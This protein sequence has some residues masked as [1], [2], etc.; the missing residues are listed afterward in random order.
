MNQI[1]LVNS[2]SKKEYKIEPSDRDENTIKQYLYIRYYKADNTDDI[3]RYHP[4]NIKLN[5]VRHNQ[6]TFY[7]IYDLL[8]TIYSD[9]LFVFEDQLHTS[10][11]IQNIYDTHM[12]NL[13]TY[14]QFIFL[15]IYITN[16]LTF[17]KQP[18]NI[19]QVI[20]K[21]TEYQDALA[22]KFMLSGKVKKNTIQK[23]LAY[24]REDDQYRY[25]ILTTTLNVVFDSSDM[26]LVRLVKFF[27]VSKYIPFI[28][29]IHNDKPYL[30][31]Y[32]HYDKETISKWIMKKGDIKKLKG[33][34]FK[35]MFDDLILT[36]ILVNTNDV[37]YKLSLMVSW[38]SSKYVSY[39][40][41]ENN[42][43]AM[44]NGVMNT[45]NHNNNLF[46]YTN[47]SSFINNT[48]VHFYLK[49]TV[50][51]TKLVTLIN[52]QNNTDFKVNITDKN[53]L[54]L[55][56]DKHIS[57][58][59]F[60]T[61]Y[62]DYPHLSVTVYS[63]ISEHQVQT[64]INKLVDIVGLHSF[65]KKDIEPV[66]Y[67]KLYIKIL[68]DKGL[69]I[70]PSRCQKKRQPILSDSKNANTLKYKNLYLSCPNPN[71]PYIGVIRKNELCCF[72]RDQTNKISYKTLFGDKFING[73]EFDRDALV[74]RYV[75]NLN[76]LIPIGSL[77]KIYDIPYFEDKTKYYIVGNNNNVYSVINILNILLGKHIT[78]VDYINFIKNKPCVYES[79]NH[80]NM[81]HM[82]SIDEYIT[83]L[84]T[85]ETMIPHNHL[86]A[87]L[88]E[89]LNITI[90]LFERDKTY[91]YTN[92]NPTNKI[93]LL[94][95]YQNN[96]QGIVY[97][98]NAKDYTFTFD[99]SVLTEFVFSRNIHYRD[100]QHIYTD[101]NLKNQIID[102]TNSCRYLLIE[103]GDI[104]GL[105]P[106]FIE[107]GPLALCKTVSLVDVQNYK[108]T[109]TNQL[110]LCKYFKMEA[111]L[112]V[113]ILKPKDVIGVK[114]NDI[115]IPVMKTTIPKGNNYKIVKENIIPE[116]T[117]W[118]ET[119]DISNNNHTRFS[120]E[121][122]FKKELYIRLKILLN[123]IIL[124]NGL[125]P[126]ILSIYRKTKM[127]YFAKYYAI[128]DILHSQVTPHISMVKEYTVPNTVLPIKRIKSY[129]FFHKNKLLFVEADY[130]VYMYK[131][132]MEILH[133]N[134]DILTKNGIS[135]EMET[136][137]KILARVDETVLIGGDAIINFFLD[138][139]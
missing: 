107:I 139:N 81:K 79:I 59:I 124:D 137:S 17:T 49:S 53:K 82:M 14:N 120:I 3:I 83:Y 39:E 70:N 131:A 10:A 28:Y 7:S 133:G 68:R 95:K 33:V 12:K 128:R 62:Q 21:Y 13:I 75:I 132:C 98:N 4:D 104:K 126:K 69:N 65:N 113:D 129:P 121:Y 76:K 51:F 71:F 47:M 108:T 48:N 8:T 122:N 31:V 38:V 92:Y 46:S 106:I 125:K 43:T 50:S 130:V 2:L 18:D 102:I 27:K 100:I 44:I 55:L 127:D 9:M 16:S 67:N 136:S 78:I 66:K 96:Y 26:S 109:L 23:N 90:V 94:S 101:F 24:I 88:I 56:Y 103:K 112:I 93:V 73:K 91:I 34:Y 117:N 97:I 119:N 20:A 42:S 74:S 6:Y 35:Y 58:L 19:N 99:S 61:I 135:R 110:R 105:Y 64:I 40:Y 84:L 85:S 54:A 22:T 15:T 32:K 60:S 87:G 30:K 89:Y 63:V 57:I 116:L 86:F 45:M 29:M 11:Y 1:T 111:I 5:E 25:S 77:G 114:V 138:T 134:H 118:L 115:Q 72:A 52:K 80:G 41:I 36:C 123:D 37:S